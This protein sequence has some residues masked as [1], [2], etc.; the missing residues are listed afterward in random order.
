[1]C[2]FPAAS[3]RW[4]NGTDGPAR[5]ALQRDYVKDHGEL[6]LHLCQPLEAGDVPDE[7][8]T[9]RI[10]QMPAAGVNA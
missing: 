10:T 1:M 8:L 5:A 6:E 9:S 2:A 7:P 4:R 3:A